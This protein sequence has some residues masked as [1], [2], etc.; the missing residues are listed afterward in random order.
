MDSDLN[1]NSHIK[2]IKNLAYYYFK[3]IGSQQDLDYTGVFTDLSKIIDQT[4]AA[5]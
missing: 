1:F 5:V 2:T 4:N 3:N